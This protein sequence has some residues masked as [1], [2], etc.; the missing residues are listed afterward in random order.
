M[1]PAV[2]LSPGKALPPPDGRLRMSPGIHRPRLRQ[3]RDKIHEVIY[4]QIARDLLLGDVSKYIFNQVSKVATDFPSAREEK[5]GLALGAA[6]GRTVPSSVPVAEASVTHGPASAAV[7]PATRDLPASKCVPRD[8]MAPTASWHV[9]VRMVASVTTRMATAP[10]GS[11]GLED[12]VRKAVTRAGLVRGVSI[13]VTV[14]MLLVILRLGSAFAHLG[15][16]ETS[17]T[18]GAGQ[19]GGSGPPE[20]SDGNTDITLC[21]K[22]T[23]DDE[24]GLEELLGK[25]KMPSTRVI[26][27]SSQG[28]DF[29]AQKEVEKQD[30]CSLLIESSCKI[31]LFFKGAFFKL[32]ME[33]GEVMD[34]ESPAS[35]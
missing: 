5:E 19:T 35:E 10:V 4:A 31:Q 14:E 1:C 32:L 11:A 33:V 26:P 20:I 25:E 23:W 34:C 13:S 16:L 30:Q 27:C 6:M 22:K 28:I 24:V 15:R 2:P 12:P 17:V 3:E 29:M 8:D 21:P 9:P 7:P 18:L